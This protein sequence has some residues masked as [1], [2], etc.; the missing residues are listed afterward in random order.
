MNHNRKF[1]FPEKRNLNRVEEAAVRRDPL[2]LR[3][4][5]AAATSQQTKQMTVRESTPETFRRIN[6]SSEGRMEM[7]MRSRSLK[8]EEMQLW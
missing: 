6:E 1:L 2:M 5:A 3:E 8:L 7:E 4:A